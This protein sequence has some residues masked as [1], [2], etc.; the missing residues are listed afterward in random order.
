MAQAGADTGPEYEAAAGIWRILGRRWTFLI[1]WNLE[2]K[3]MRF[4]E[5]K[6]ALGGIANTV[7][8]DRLA[9]LE[10]EGLVARNVVQGRTEY[11]LTA[12]ARELQTI[13]REMGRWRA[14][15]ALL[16]VSDVIFS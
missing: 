8:S 7:L 9:E 5:L 13:L 1:L 16:S 6:K 3:A 4:N 2:N 12:G 15:R 11:G 14:R 10:G